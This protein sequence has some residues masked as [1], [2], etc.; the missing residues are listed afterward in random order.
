M[1]V[2]PS[3]AQVHG[4]EVHSVGIVKSLAEKTAV[5]LQKHPHEDF[6]LDANNAVT[7][8]SNG[9]LPALKRLEASSIGTSHTNVFFG[10]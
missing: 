5:A 10:R 7:A 1:G 2:T 9:L 3:D 6:E 4:A 8:A